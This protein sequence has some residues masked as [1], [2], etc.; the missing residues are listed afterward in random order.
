MIVDLLPLG[1]SVPDLREIKSIAI[2]CSSAE[3]AV[4]LACTTLQEVLRSSSKS[5]LRLF[6]LPRTS[7]FVESLLTNV[8]L[9]DKVKLD[10]LSLGAFPLEN[11]LLTAMT[12]FAF[13]EAAIVSSL[14]LSGSADH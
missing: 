14:M 7:A 8:G 6:I 3:S 2:F 4:K 13:R 5:E 9:F 11:D 10:S 1:S 12:P